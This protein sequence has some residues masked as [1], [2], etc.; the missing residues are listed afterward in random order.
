[1]VDKESR[2]M[3]KCLQ[4]T[5][6]KQK[7]PI[8]VQKEERKEK[9][10]NYLEHPVYNDISLINGEINRMDCQVLQLK[11]KELHLDCRGKREALK[12]RLKEYWKVEKLIEAGL[13]E[14]RTNRNADFLVVIDFE[15]TCEERNPPGYPH[16]IIEFPAVLIASGGEDCPRI[17]DVF[18]AFVRPVINPHLSEFCKSLTGIDQETVDAADTFP[19]VHQRFVEWMEVKHGLGSRA[20]YL[21][22][23]DGPF[24]MGR[25]MYLQM[26][27]L[28]H[29]YPAYA[30]HWANLR[31]VFA[32][33]YKE[34]FYKETKDFK[35]P[36]L[37][38][39]LTQLG[40]EFEGQP[41]SGVDDAKNIARIVVK[42]LYDR[43]VIRVN[44]RIAAVAKGVDDS[45]RTG[46]KLLSV[47]P[48]MR[49]EAESWYK[50][51]KCLVVV[52]ETTTTT[53]EE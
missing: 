47:V 49:K 11:C 10:S 21:I 23:T 31:K 36:G 48:V 29:D 46:A 16:E 45:N 32:N 44:E 14:R 7:K 13:M 41:H 43:A 35:L 5:P 30:S 25:F 3:Y 51:Q 28:G 37:Q 9:N 39:M 20:T 8:V 18:H 1:M 15:A 52:K 6:K 12:R 22:V 42:L 24:D 17:M 38:T 40:M 33:F 19:M 26:R 27:H 34:G 2:D 4:R 53:Q 50:K